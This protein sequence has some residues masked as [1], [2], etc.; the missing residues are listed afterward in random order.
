MS[1]KIIFKEDEEKFFQKCIENNS[2]PKNDALKQIV[3]KR[4]MKDFDEK[5]IYS[6][7][8]VNEIIKKH[9]EDYTTLRRELVNFGYMQRDSLKGEYKVVKKELTKDDYLKNT[10]LKRAAISIKILKEDE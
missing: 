8:E 9:F 2:I 1:D 3:F 5:R 6:E 7:Q 4:L 10:L